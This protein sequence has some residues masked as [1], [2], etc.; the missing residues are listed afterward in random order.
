MTNA[1][2]IKEARDLINTVLVR[3]YEKNEFGMTKAGRKRRLE[4]ALDHL[5][6]VVEKK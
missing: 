6:D 4:M 3:G 1:K 2:K 5:D